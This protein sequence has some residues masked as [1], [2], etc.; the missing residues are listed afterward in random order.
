MPKKP[1]LKA[2]SFIEL[3]I[4]VVVIGLLV[5]AIMQGGKAVGE[6]KRSTAAKLTL[7]SPVAEI[8]NLVLWLET[9]S[10][11]SFDSA[12]ARN[13]RAVNI[14]HDINPTAGATRADATQSGTNRPTYYIDSVTSLPLVKF[15]GTDDYMNLPDKTIPY[16]NSNY[17]VFLVSKTNALSA[18]AVLCAYSST[19]NYSNCFRYA[20]TA[21]FYNYWYNNDLSTTVG[22]VVKD[23]LQIFSF[24]Y[25]NTTE[26]GRNAYIN[27]VS[28]AT[29]VTTV[30]RASVTTPHYVSSILEP[31]NG[32]IGEIIVFDRTLTLQERKDIEGYLGKKWGIR[33]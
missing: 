9:T 1:L 21:I 5:A 29:A 4:S 13:G 24:T 10:D 7:T 3:S 17:T 28:K 15:D 6:A 22:S 2:F 25:S 18:G 26:I 23:K 32:Y 27:G 20:A 16:G 31:L 12:D 14:W 8:D 33:I 19:N 30:N 11:K